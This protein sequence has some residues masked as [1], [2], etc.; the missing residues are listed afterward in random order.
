MGV[1]PFFSDAQRRKL[2]EIRREHAIESA[3]LTPAERLRRADEL[4]RLA[5]AVRPE[6]RSS[7]DESREIM[8]GWKRRR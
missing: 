6:S 2:D 7:A 4:R 1:V 5:S 3:R 8:R